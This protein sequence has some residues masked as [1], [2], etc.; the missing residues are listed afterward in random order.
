MALSLCRSSCIAR[1]GTSP[2]PASSR[3][4]PVLRS[5]GDDVGDAFVQIFSK[6]NDHGKPAGAASEWS[7]KVSHHDAKRRP[8]ND[9]G[10]AKGTKLAASVSPGAAQEAQEAGGDN[11]VMIADSDSAARLTQRR[12]AAVDAAYETPMHQ[13]PA[14]A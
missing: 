12:S 11:E 7:G 13:A 10:K 9:S 1:P 5:V 4:L 3:R 14:A 2:R 8:F 6:P